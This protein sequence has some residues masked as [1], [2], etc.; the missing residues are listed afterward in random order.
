MRNVI[1][2]HHCLPSCSLGQIQ[3]FPS[4]WSCCVGKGGERLPKVRY[5]GGTGVLLLGVVAFAIRTTNPMRTF[6]WCSSR[7]MVVLGNASSCGSVRHRATCSGRT[8]SN[9]YQTNHHLR[10]LHA[11]MSATAQVCLHLHLLHSSPS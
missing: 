8:R 10:L 5:S 1:R 4:Q 6:C 7:Q 2:W 3:S 11:R 9:Y